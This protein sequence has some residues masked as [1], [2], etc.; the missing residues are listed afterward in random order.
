MS[1]GDEMRLRHW[2][3]G[4][5]FGAAGASAALVVGFVALLVLVPGVVWAAHEPTRPLGLAG[6][7]VGVGAGAGGLIALIDNP[8]A[9]FDATTV[10]VVQSCYSADA[11]PYVI[12]ALLLVAAGAAMSVVSLRRTSRSAQ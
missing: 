5:L 4:I 11:S 7:L 12:A 10:G 3:L 9:A 6:L 8:C 2:V 1:K